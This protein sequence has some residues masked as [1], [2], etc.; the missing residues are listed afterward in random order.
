MANLQ[1]SGAIDFKNIQ[2]IMGGSYPISMNEYYGRGGA[3]PGSGGIA[4]S[5]FYGAPDRISSTLTCNNA[6]PYDNNSSTRTFN[7]SI[8]TSGRILAAK[9]VFYHTTDG[10]YSE[11][12]MRWLQV[13]GR[14]LFGYFHG[15]ASERTETRTDFVQN[16][17]VNKGDIV[18]WNIGDD[19]D[20]DWTY[21]RNIRLELTIG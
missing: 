20:Q 16:V 8:P 7:G 12:Y 3:I 2:D 9:L 18:K 21:F 5:Q 1:G 4:I 13:G 15:G 19:V 6:G 14:T 11:A 17:Y 10:S